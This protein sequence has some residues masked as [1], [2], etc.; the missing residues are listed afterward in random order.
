MAELRALLETLGF[1]DVSTLLATGNAVFRSSGLAGAKLEALL[2]E[3]IARRIGPR[4]AV[5]VRD[6][7]AFDRIMAGNPF[8]ED[9]AVIPSRVT[10]TL[11]RRR[12]PAEAA[13]AFEEAVRPPEKVK[14]VDDV[15]WLV[16]PEGISK[17]EIPA[18]VW[19]RAF[20]DIPHT[21]RN[22]N[23]LLKIQAAARAI[24]AAPR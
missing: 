15:L 5:L 7:Q 14:I 18:A 20:K 24:A 16:H 17:S 19:R 2:E 21:A 4:L 23:T 8:P 9:C 6:A 11:L 22:W 1:T 13:R 10:A 3:E 12:P